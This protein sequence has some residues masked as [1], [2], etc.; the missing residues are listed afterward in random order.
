MSD[1]QGIKQS[2]FD[3]AWPTPG[4]GGTGLQ[5][6]GGG[7][8]QGSGANGISNSPFSAAVV[9]VPSGECTPVSD[10]GYPPDYTVQV[11]GG[12]PAGSHAPWDVTS[13]R[14]TVDQK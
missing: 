10:I 2:P 8:D 3:D 13:S 12:S 9:P 11:E 5:G 4:V 7:L 14:N 6:I 1:Q